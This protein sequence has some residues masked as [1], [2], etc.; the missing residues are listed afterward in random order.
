MRKSPFTV[1][2][3]LQAAMDFLDGIRSASQIA[4]DLGPKH[5]N[6]VRKWAYA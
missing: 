6:T 4:N 2:Q 1:E 5:Q 3:R